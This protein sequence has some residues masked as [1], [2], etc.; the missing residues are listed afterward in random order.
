L[1]KA[2]RDLPVTR[3]RQGYQRLRLGEPEP[4]EAHNVTATPP[5]WFK[6]LGDLGPVAIRDIEAILQRLNK[7][8]GEP[9][10]GEAHDIEASSPLVFGGLDDPGPEGARIEAALLLGPVAIC[11]IEATLPRLTKSLGEPGGTGGGA[12]QRGVR[13]ITTGV[14]VPRRSGT[15]G[16]ARH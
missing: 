3:Q 9:G 4:G 14:R 13:V 11:D 6:G 10:P 8:L 1:T 2:N 15:G 12:R 5:R 7:S 16:G